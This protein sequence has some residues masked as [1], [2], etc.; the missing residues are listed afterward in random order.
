MSFLGYRV[1]FP[2]HSKP[3]EITAL[4]RNTDI[5]QMQG[6]AGMGAYFEANTMIEINIFCKRINR[7]NVDPQLGNMER[8]VMRLICGFNKG[9]IAGVSDMV[10]E[11]MERIYN[12]NDTYSKTEWRT[13]ALVRVV[14]EF[15]V[16]YVDSFSLFSFSPPTFTP[17]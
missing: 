13:R 7:D 4:Q 14:Y 5:K 17:V 12:A 11:R 15:Q 10:L 16:P 6:P 8:E 3:Y 2:D 1:G 9:D